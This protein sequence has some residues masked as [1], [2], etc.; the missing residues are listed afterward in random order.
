MRNLVFVL[1]ILIFNFS[2]NNSKITT[3]KSSDMNDY[4][5]LYQSEYGGSGEEK[6]EVFVNAE[7]FSKMWNS[8]INAV[9]GQT[10]VPAIDFAKQMVVMRH[11]QSRNSGGT[12]YEI[13]SVKQT[14]NKTEIF[15]K[16]TPPSGMSTTAIT[17]PLMIV[18]VKK[19]AQP[20]VEFK[21]QQ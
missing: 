17:N 3:D 5:V 2:C 11:F 16:V 1:G 12:T 9:S 7:E 20:Q 18:A 13:Q 10:D 15:Y 4:E 6:T 8:Y 14:E 21:T 19:T